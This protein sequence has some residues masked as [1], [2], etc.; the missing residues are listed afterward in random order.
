MLLPSGDN[1]TEYD[2]LHMTTIGRA[3]GQP[4]PVYVCA[5]VNNALIQSNPQAQVVPLTDRC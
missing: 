5:A 4:L 2:C 3:V 1:V